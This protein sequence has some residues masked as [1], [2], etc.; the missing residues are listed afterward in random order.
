MSSHWR[1][2]AQTAILTAQLCRFRTDRQS[3]RLKYPYVIQTKSQTHNK[4]SNKKKL[5]STFANALAA[6]WKGFIK[7]YKRPF[8]TRFILGHRAGPSER[9]A[10]CGVK[11]RC[12]KKKIVEIQIFK[13]E[14]YV[15]QKIKLHS[16][17]T[18]DL[19]KC[20]L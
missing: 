13:F 17:F 18:A 12:L 19:C 4:K 10:R 14:K 11:T 16:L 7:K 8:Y 3:T 2:H 15:R 5:E 20:L 6:R 9:E 1:V